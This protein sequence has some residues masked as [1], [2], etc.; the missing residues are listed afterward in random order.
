MNFNIRF[1]FT[2]RRERGV[3][4]AGLESGPLRP[5]THLHYKLHVNL[6]HHPE[7]IVGKYTIHGACG[8]PSSC[9]KH[10]LFDVHNT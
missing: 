8:I 10:L 6:K 1:L 7:K 3:V 5:L 4:A 9:L 2:Q